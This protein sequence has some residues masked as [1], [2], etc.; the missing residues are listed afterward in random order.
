MRGHIMAAQAKAKAIMEQNQREAKLRADIVKNEET[1]DQLVKEGEY[2]QGLDAYGESLKGLSLVKEE[3]RDKEA[4]KRVQRKYDFVN[5]IV[6]G[7][8]HFTNRNYEMACELSKCQSRWE[9]LG[10]AGK[11]LEE[12]LPDPRHISVLNRQKAEIPILTGNHLKQSKVCPRPQY[13]RPG[14]F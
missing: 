13:C 10:F 1:G 6:D 2:K 8:E 5:A 11:A 12:R 7:D 14:W 4:E 3:D 9:G